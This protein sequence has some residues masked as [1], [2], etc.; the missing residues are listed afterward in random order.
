MTLTASAENTQL[1][2]G[3]SEK[4]S[5]ETNGTKQDKNLYKFNGC[6]NV[7]LENNSYDGGMNLKAEIQNM[8]ASEIKLKGDHIAINGGGNMTETAGDIYYV[9]SDEN[10]L[11]VSDTG[12]VTAVGEGTASIRT[13]AVSGGRKYEGNTIEFTVSGS[14][15]GV[16]PTGLEIDAEKEQIS[17]GE[18]LAF[19]AK[20]LGKEGV[21]QQVTWKVLTP[22]TGAESDLATIDDK[23]MLTA[24]KQVW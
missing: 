10:I 1:A 2:V 18:T 19:T 15:E 16:L 22:D 23:G 3:E 12:I 4:I 7:V 20:A 21:N 11:K 9:S 17:V 24:K 8:D 6:K 13:F 14:V 5:V